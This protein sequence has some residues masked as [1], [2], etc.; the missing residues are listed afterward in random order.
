M[1][2]GLSSVVERKKRGYLSYLSLEA[3]KQNTKIRKMRYTPTYF[4][5]STN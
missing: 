1:G 4:E 2:N 5:G 3:K